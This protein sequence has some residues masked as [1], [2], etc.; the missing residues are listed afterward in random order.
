MDKFIA[1]VK[2]LLSA[3][4][5]VGALTSCGKAGTGKSDASR[6]GQGLFSPKGKNFRTTA[7]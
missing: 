5:A 4:L 2:I 7:L 6:A 3:L 1:F